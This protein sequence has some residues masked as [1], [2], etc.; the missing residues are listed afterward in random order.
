M[1]DFKRI[2]VKVNAATGRQI[3]SKGSVIRETDYFRLLFDETVIIC[4]ELV[5]VDW[6][7][8]TAAMTARPVP[9]DMTLAAFGDNDFNPATAFMFLTEQNANPTHVNGAGDW[10]NNGTANRALGQLSFRINTNTDRF[11]LAMNSTNAKYYFVITGV[12]SGETEKSVLAYFRFTAQNRPSSSSGVPASADP[13]YLNAQQTVALLKAAPERQFSI[14]GSTNWHTDQADTDR[15]YR[16]RR[17][18][19]EWSDPIALIK[20]NDVKVYFS[21][22][23]LTAWHF[24][25]AGGDAYLR[26]S[27]DGGITWGGAVFFKGERGLQGIQ[28]PPPTP[29][30]DLVNAA[31]GTNCTWGAG[32]DALVLTV[33]HNL[34]TTSLSVC[35]RDT[36]TGRLFINEFPIEQIIVVNANT[37]KIYFAELPA[38]WYEIIVG[39]GVSAA[40]SS[41]PASNAEIEAKGDIAKYVNPAG[42]VHFFNAVPVDSM[43]FKSA[44]G[45]VFMK[46]IDDNG[47]DKIQ[48]ISS[49]V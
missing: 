20:P 21:A 34:N 42:L 31:G 8:G 6:T 15:F 11:P 38:V 39:Y 47:V 24:P 16:E 2:P 26:F 45:S 19:G 23:G 43:L 4:A 14:D 44:N 35:L 48:Q 30:S 29:F 1:S 3:D 41:S 36:V 13:E 37:L 49:G 28:G 12:P 32:D 7:N 5:D 17:L 9:E 25:S 27:T 40:N 22:D 10:I 18:N 46:W 33:P